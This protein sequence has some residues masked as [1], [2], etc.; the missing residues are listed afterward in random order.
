[1]THFDEWDTLS[2]EQRA[3]LRKRIFVE[4]ERSED[5]LTMASVG[6]ALERSGV[7]A[8]IESIGNALG[9]MLASGAVSS[10]THAQPQING[11]LLIWRAKSRV[12]R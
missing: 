2:L 9:A 4:L 6:Y 7:D 5:G 1:M 10:T 8:S 3:D 11:P 12:T